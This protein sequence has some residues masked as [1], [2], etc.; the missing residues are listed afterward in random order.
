VKA[1]TAQQVFERLYASADALNR[2]NVLELIGPG[3]HASLCDLGCDDGSWT[4]E[5]GKACGNPKLYGVEIVASRAEMARGRGIEV[6]VSDLAQ[7][8]PFPD[9]EMKVVHANQ[10]IEHVTDVDHFMSETQRILEIGGL[11]IISTENGSSWHNI[12]AASMG[13]QIFSATNISKR[14]GGIGNPL[15]LHRGKTGSVAS[16]THKTIFNFRGFHE[17]VEAHHLRVVDV[18]GAGYHPLPA[19][20]GRLDPRHA[21]FLALKAVKVA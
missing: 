17:L 5:L 14:A 12:F 16:W 19:T 15:A 3:P 10:V 21:H 9:G 2:R 13:W 7:R 6:A 4:V 18:I 20:F 8:F 1:P 11:A